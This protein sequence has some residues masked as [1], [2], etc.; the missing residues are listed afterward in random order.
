MENRSD[1]TLL[2]RY[3]R[4]VDIS[5]DLASTL[6]LDTLLNQIVKAAGDLTDS[7]A[8]SIILYDE[9]KNELYFHSSTNLDVRVM[10]G[11]EVPVDGSIAGTIVKTR[12][13]IIVMRVEDDP[14]HFQGVGETTKFKT[15]SLLGVPLIAKDKVVGVI[16]T[17]NKIEGDFTKEDEKL[18]SALAAQAAIAIQNARLFQQSDLISEL[19]HELRTPLASI[20]TAAHLL[21]RPEI[22]QIQRASMAETIQK[23]TNRLTDLATSFLDLARLE[24]GR[25]QFKLEET[26]LNVLILESI[27]VMKSRIDADNLSLKSD[28]SEHLPQ[29]L[30]DTDKIKQVILNLLSNAVKYN[31]PAGSITIS[32]A[33][34]VKTLSF[35]IGDTGWGMLPNQ[36]EQ[37]FE[38]FYRV[39]GSDKKAPGTGLGLSICK[40][41]IE[42]HDGHIEVTSEYGKGT[43]F[44]VFLPI[45]S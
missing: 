18:L 43:T 39:P 34:Q 26:D 1:H 27:D 32:S 24:S 21:T 10:R 41:I 7:K 38:K 42:A 37:L 40:K 3:L 6:D 29:I 16:E 14:R 36:M 11:L 31:R 9:S 15:E 13:P 23:E 19:I 8:A 45:S 2:E 30:V 22:S 44:T 33:M 17:L 4:L 20:Q 35:S 5:H 25:S 12:Q 28:L